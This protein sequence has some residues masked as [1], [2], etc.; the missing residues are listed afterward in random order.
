MQ[1]RV[2]GWR[3]LLIPFLLGVLLAPATLTALTWTAINLEVTFGLILVT[4]FVY[5]FA[6]PWKWCPAVLAALT[7][8]VPPYPYLVDFSESGKIIM[9]SSDIYFRVHFIR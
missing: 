4:V 5:F 8:A 3:I 1:N 9:R 7:I 2:P 6:A